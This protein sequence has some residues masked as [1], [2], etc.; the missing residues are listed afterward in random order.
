L[1]IFT[2]AIYNARNKLENGWKLTLANLL[3]SAMKTRIMKKLYAISFAAIAMLLSLQSS[4]QIQ[5]GAQGSYLKGTGDNKASLW[6]GGV[7]A[8]FFLGNFLA[9]GG[10]VRTYPKQTSKVTVGNQTITTG[11][12][13]TNISGSADILLGKKND[14][15]QPFI[16]ADA[17]VS[18]NNQTVTTTNSSQQNVENKNGKTFFLLSPKV[19]LNLG[20]LPSFGVFGTA[21]Y[22]LT[23]GSGDQKDVSVNN[24]P[25]P[26]KST[27]VDKYFTFDVGVYFRLVGAKK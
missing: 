27:P 25:N 19:G 8:K 16:G 3:H 18:I 24:T 1:Q 20:L 17:G 5:I 13:I 14:L 4:A 6:G 9:F 7:H 23:F 21:Q 15:I 2:T 11:D 26:F 10:V 12:F 22:N